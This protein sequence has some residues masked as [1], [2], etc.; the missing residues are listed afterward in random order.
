MN[1]IGAKTDATAKSSIGTT[2]TL[3]RER[4][5]GRGLD[6]F[7][8][9][10]ICY[11]YFS[12]GFSFR[13]ETRYR[14]FFRSFWMLFSNLVQIIVIRLG[15]ENLCSEHNQFIN[16]TVIARCAG[17]WF[18]QKWDSLKERWTICPFTVHRSSFSAYEP[19]P[20][21]TTNKSRRCWMVHIHTCICCVLCVACMLPDARWWEGAV[22]HAHTFCWFWTHD[23]HVVQ[24]RSAYIDCPL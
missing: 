3:K 18:S 17:V 2:R 11:C 22:Y 23:V 1:W 24:E 8:F 15:R 13:A 21:E 20:K 9:I 6:V 5:R 12:D 16:Q 19:K 10:C 14:R 7:V 4:E